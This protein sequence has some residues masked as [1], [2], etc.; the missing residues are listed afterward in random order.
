MTCAACGRHLIEQNQ[1]PIFRIM[2]VLD[3]FG[4]IIACWY[5]CADA[6]ICGN[7]ARRAELL[8]GGR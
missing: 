3:V 2:P 1:W 5:V 4:R 7:P 6:S 8:K